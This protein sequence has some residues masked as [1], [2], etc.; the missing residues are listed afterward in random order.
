MNQTQYQVVWPPVSRNTK[1]LIGFLAAQW[2]ALILIEPLRT[3]VSEW[4]L[5]PTSTPLLVQPWQVMTYGFFDN[6][7]LSILFAAVGIW[8]FGAEVEQRWGAKKWWLIQLGGILLAGAFAWL[9]GLVTSFAM[10]PAPFIQQGWHPAV[11]A[12]ATAY[13]IRQW[14]AQMSI[15]GIPMNG[16]ILLTFFVGLSVVMSAISLNFPGVGLE[17]GGVLAG[18]IATRP[19]GLIRD[20]KTRFRMWQARRHLKVVKKPEDDRPDRKMMN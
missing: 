6:D 16:R 10:T 11:T 13:C 1:L 3:F 14:N 5:L 7:F 17:A 9:V 2:L 19:S 20:L 12:L 4:L 8:I 18:Y 15:F